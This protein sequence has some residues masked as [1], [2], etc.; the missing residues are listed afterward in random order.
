MPEKDKIKIVVADAL[1][2][3][4]ATEAYNLIFSDAPYAQ[5]LSSPAICDAT[6][7]GWIASGALCLIETR[8]DEELAL[9]ENFVQV[10]ERIYG[11]AKIS[12]YIYN[13]AD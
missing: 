7:K 11:I 12:F 1:R 5:N 13:Q 6:D 9:P 8:K 2:L 4:P 10:D 3:P